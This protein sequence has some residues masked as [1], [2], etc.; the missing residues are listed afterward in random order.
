[1]EIVGCQDIAACDYNINATD[2][3]EC[4]EN[5]TECDLCSGEQDG[6]GIVIINAALDGICDTCEDGFII[7]NDFDDDQICN[8]NENL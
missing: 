7:D 2:S 1:M 8:D 3:S 6:T 4:L 5:P